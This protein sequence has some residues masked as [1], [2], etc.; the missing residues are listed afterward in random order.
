MLCSVKNDRQKLTSPTDP[1]ITTVNRKIVKY[2]WIIEKIVAYK[3]LSKFQLSSLVVVTAGAGFICTGLP[4]DIANLTSV[5]M[6]TAF[7]AASANS[8]NQIFERNRDKNMN[9]TKN[10]PLPSGRVSP[11]EAVVFGVTSAAIGVG[12]LYAL[13]NPLVAMLGGANILLYA[14]P[15]TFSKRYT[16]ANTW[17]GAVVGAIPPVMGWAA[18]TGGSI[19][20]ADPV[21]LAAIL[22]LWQFP[23]FF[24]LSWLYREDY[25]RG[26]FQMVPVNDPDGA[27]TA[28]LILR[29]SIYLTALPPLVTIGGLTSSMFAVEGA[30]VNAYLLYLAYQ[31]SKERTNANARKVFLTSL[32]YLPVILA[33]FI[34]HNTLWEENKLK[35]EETESNNQVLPICQMRQFLKDHCVHEIFINKTNGDKSILCPV[36]ISEKVASN[37]PTLDEITQSTVSVG[38][39]NPQQ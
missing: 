20:A 28:S 27:R 14:L 22:Y 5:C 21:V 35:E 29:Y 33:G 37:A 38:P 1:T 2:P 7:C 31:Y 18:A 17:V 13:T 19:L 32:W 23:H 34:F 24:A 11:Q 6:G 16:E 10:R 12:S 3:E 15:Y 36:I 8:F 30:V 39:S 4:I 26:G 25:A 9:R